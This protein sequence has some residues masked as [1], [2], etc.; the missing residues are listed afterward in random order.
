MSACS[1]C[2]GG[3]GQRLRGE[4]NGVAWGRAVHVVPNAGALRHD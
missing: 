4:L 1:A 2:A 3:F